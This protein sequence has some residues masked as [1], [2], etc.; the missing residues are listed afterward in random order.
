M[1]SRLS[2]KINSFCTQIH[3]LHVLRKLLES[4]IFYE[5]HVSRELDFAIFE[6]Y[7]TYTVATYLLIFVLS[8][9]ECLAGNLL[10]TFRVLSYCVYDATCGA[11]L[12]VFVFK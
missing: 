3:T 8:H 5:G 6:I 4:F 10:Y 11:V 1:R 9:F 7:V 12:S 2:R